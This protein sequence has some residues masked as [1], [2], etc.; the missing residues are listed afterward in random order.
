MEAANINFMKWAL[1]I[2]LEE[3]STRKVEIPEE[4]IQSGDY[5]AVMRLDGLDP[6]IMFGTGSRSGHSV[7]AMR[8]DGELYI[9]ESQDAWYWPTHRIQRTPFKAWLR[10]AENCDFHVVHMPLNKE[11]RAKFD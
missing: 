3:R 10:F 7:M 2:E 8:F 1:N 11:M 9:V 6:M 5:F 4:N